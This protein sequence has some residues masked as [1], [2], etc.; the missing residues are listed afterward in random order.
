MGYRLLVLSLF[1]LILLLWFLL[2]VPSLIFVL[3]SN[4]LTLFDHVCIV[5]MSL[6]LVFF[7]FRELKKKN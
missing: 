1:F 7:V 4:D 3:K 2:F 6:S 5:L